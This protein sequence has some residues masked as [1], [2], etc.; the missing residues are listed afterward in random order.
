MRR[1]RV[2]ARIATTRPGRWP[3]RC[4]VPRRR[5]FGAG[6]AVWRCTDVG[7]RGACHARPNKPDRPPLWRARHLTASHLGAAATAD[8]HFLSVSRALGPHGELQGHAPLRRQR[9]S[10][11]RAGGA[12]RRA[13][14]RQNPQP[15]HQ[16]RHHAAG[17]R[18]ARGEAAQVH[19]AAA[20]RARR[21]V[22]FAARATLLG[23]PPSAA[24]APAHAPPAAARLQGAEAAHA[25]R[26]LRPELGR[27]GA[28]RAAR[29]A[30][31]PLRRTTLT[32][33]RCARPTARSARAS[34]A[35]C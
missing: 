4:A 26:H 27:T 9:R 10:P 11:R 1:A 8:E 25:Q 19:H 29:P 15:R 14:R 32:R 16:P 6:A 13:Q 5:T 21:R 12:H 20:G 17:G 28:P 34:C 2:H 3:R 23:T 24:F 31:R 33:T 22:D 18:L 35:G 30:S 7:T